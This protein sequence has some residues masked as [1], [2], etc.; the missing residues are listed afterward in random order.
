MKKILALVLILVCVFSTNVYAKPVTSSGASILIDAE[1][2]QILYSHNVNE[3]MYPAS[4]T[5]LLTVYLACEKSRMGDVITV[6]KTAVDT[7]PRDTS[8]IALD[9]GEK[10]TV[11]DAVNAAMLMS[12]NDAANVLAEHISGS[13]DEFAKLMNKTA[14]EMGVKNSNFVN[15]SGL[16]DEMHYTTA[17]DFAMI[18]KSALAN[19]KFRDFISAQE[20]TIAST[21]KKKDTRYMVTQHRMM[22]WPQYA[23]LGVVG[24]K[25]GYTSQA[26]Y[27]LVTYCEK[28]D[29]KLISVVLKSDTFTDVY[30]DT[31]TLLEYGTNDFNKVV[32]D[33]QNIKPYEEGRVTL[34]PKGSVT[35]L[36]SSEYNKNDFTYDYKI[37]T[38]KVNVL[39]PDK[40]VIATLDTDKIV[41]PSLFQKIIKV[42]LRVVISV[43][44]VLLLLIILFIRSENKKKKK[45][46]KMK[47]ILYK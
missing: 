11:E 29:K 10:I 5:K 41:K 9:Y 16:H 4:I 33:G 15:P 24:G 2:G 8:N 26:K 6:S 37:D 45:R 32:L 31:Q 21:N 43:V 22:H 14:N 36:L 34:I 30:K 7:V 18:V 19:E 13:L 46:D 39:L 23:T 42:T 44:V 35:F 47:K 27:T 28:N 25:S 1:T 3:R 17:Y 12:A 20:Y 40:T 38:Q